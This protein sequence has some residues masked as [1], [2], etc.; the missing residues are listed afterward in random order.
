MFWAAMWFAFSATAA[1]AASTENSWNVLVNVDSGTPYATNG[2][3]AK[4]S[5][6]LKHAQAVLGSLEIANRHSKSMPSALYLMRLRTRPPKILLPKVI[7]KIAVEMENG[8]VAMCEIKI[9]QPD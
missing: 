1:S 7:R 9:V 3:V 4:K 6:L 2:F 8:V 5:E